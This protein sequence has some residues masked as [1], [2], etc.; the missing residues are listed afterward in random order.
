M[1]GAPRR[2]LNLCIGIKK[3]GLDPIIITEKNTKLYE[4]AI[5][6]GISVHALS[7]SSRLSQRNGKLLNVNLGI[8]ITF[9]DLIIHNIRFYYL[10]KSIAADAIW[11]RGSKPVAFI[12]WQYIFYRRPIFWDIDYEPPHTGLVK[13]LHWIG[14]KISTQVIFQYRNAA[15]LIFPKY[16]IERY[17]DKFVSYIP[18]IRLPKRYMPPTYVEPEVK[19]AQVGTICNRKNQSLAVEILNSLC[20]VRP[21]LKLSFSICYDAIID[22]KI[23]R[24]IIGVR[25]EVELQDLGWIDDIA[26]VLQSTN[27]LLLPSLDEG[28]PNVVQEAMSYGVLVVANEVGGIPEVIK[29]DINGFIIPR[30]SDYTIWC[31]TILKVL[32]NPEKFRSLQKCAQKTAYQEFGMDHWSE[33]YGKLIR[34][35]I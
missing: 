25:S 11:I 7:L 21:E 10:A 31:K 17:Q 16:L 18:G 13:Y 32:S 22:E 28:V 5:N 1:S 20:T 30:G 35:N 15:S 6:H 33:Q 14:L 2:L 4:E 27:I 26:P 12:L 19:F 34:E 29:D 24:E 8:L 3:Q 23:Y 9:I